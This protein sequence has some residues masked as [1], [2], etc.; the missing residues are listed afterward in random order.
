MRA[1]AFTLETEAMTPSLTLPHKGEGTE[2][3]LPRASPPVPRDDSE[4]SRAAAR[5]HAELVGARA[6][7][8]L[9]DEARGAGRRAAFLDTLAERV[10]AALGRVD[11]GEVEAFEIAHRELAEDVVEHRGG[12]LDRVVALHRA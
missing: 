3:P 2:T 7:Q 8:P 4:P 11:M 9:R 10:E 5:D 6:R 1:N 12:V